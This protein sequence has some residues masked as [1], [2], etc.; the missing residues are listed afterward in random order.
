MYRDGVKF[1]G[2][3]G[4]FRQ[5]VYGYFSLSRDNGLTGYE[6][7]GIIEGVKNREKLSRSP[8]VCP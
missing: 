5:H 7:N 8:V 6:Y 4:I 1:V 2:V 3:L